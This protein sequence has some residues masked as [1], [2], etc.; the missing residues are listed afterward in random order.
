LAIDLH[1]RLA[2]NEALIPEIGMSSPTRQVEVGAGALLPTLSRDELAAYLAVHGSSSAWFRLKWAVDF[3]ALVEREHGGSIAALYAKMRAAGAGRAADQ[4]LLLIDRLFG[5]L[6]DEPDLHRVLRRS[7]PA[8]HLETI[9]WG[10]MRC[11][12]EPV[13]PTRV[14]FGTAPIHL[15]QLLLRSDPGFLAA[16]M[17]RVARTSLGRLQFRS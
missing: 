1:S 10:M 9:A 13:E 5:T 6:A 2:D 17:A 3:A 16:E 7:R 8:R 14:R 15:S 4:A 11:G 12:R